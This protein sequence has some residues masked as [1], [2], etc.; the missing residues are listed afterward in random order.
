[1]GEATGPLTGRRVLDL[2]QAI[3]GPYVGRIL[4]DLGADVVKVEWTNGDVTNR[5][6]PPTAG[7]TGLFHHM[8]AGKRGIGLDLKSP[9]AGDLIRR[10]AAQADVVVENFRPGVLAR[11]GLGYADLAAGNPGL[12]MASVS[13]FGQTGPEAGR[14]AYAPVIHAESGLLARQAAIDGRPIA[15]IAMSLADQITALHTTIAILAALDQRATTGVGQHVGVGMLEAM[16]A[17]DDK[18]SEAIDGITDPADSRGY[19]WE[20]T[21]GSIL[22]AADVR[23]LWR[24]LST[25]AGL[26][27]LVGPEASAA[28]KFSGRAEQ[29]AGW[30]MSFE[31]RRDL[32]AALD[33]ASIAWADVRD[34][35]TVFDS[36]TLRHGEVVVQVDD[37]AG[38]TRGVVRMPYRFSGSTSTVRGPAPRRGQHDRDVLAEW[39]GATE[40]E[41]DRLTADGTLQGD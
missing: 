13:G 34:A 41:I 37:H 24:R 35:S 30:M 8:N 9:A 20:A 26:R 36:P 7:L 33:A 40:T 31:D 2:S 15:D 39:L 12:V 27:D 16:V 11:A 19:V 6:G 18:A 28:A 17:T 38:G 3:A 21:G 1:M 5:F 25:S 29:I 4:A 23:T 32:L 10:L 14:A 22:V